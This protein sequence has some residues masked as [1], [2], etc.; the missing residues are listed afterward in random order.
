MPGR[1]EI[2][3]ARWQS[4]N[5]LKWFAR[6]EQSDRLYA[7]LAD[8]PSQEQETQPTYLRVHKICPQELENREREE[9]K[10]KDM[11][12]NLEVP[13]Q[14]QEAGH[15]SGD[16]RH[17]CGG[18]KRQVTVSCFAGAG[19]PREHHT[20]HAEA[21]SFAAVMR[22]ALCVREAPQETRDMF[23]TMLE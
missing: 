3:N 2:Q 6:K 10:T 15:I 5:C 22:A 14:L 23:Q 20:V 18:W 1:K 12:P 21:L 9:S 7:E 17:M 8:L 16:G 4:S 11:D 19:F 13:K